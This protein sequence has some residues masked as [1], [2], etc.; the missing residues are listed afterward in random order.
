[1]VYKGW[2]YDIVLLSLRV[3]DRDSLFC[4]YATIGHDLRYTCSSLY[5]LWF[6]GIFIASKQ[7]GGGGVQATAS[8]ASELY[9]VDERR[10][11]LCYYYVHRYMQLEEYTKEK[12]ILATFSL[13]LL[14]IRKNCIMG[15]K[16]RTAILRNGKVTALYIENMTNN[17]LLNESQ[18]RRHCC[19]LA[20]QGSRAK[21][22]W[23]WLFWELIVQSMKD[24]FLQWLQRQCYYCS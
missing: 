15:S 18:R 20:E 13:S 2:Q 17:H 22:W 5:V 7:L 14:L 24:Y 1:M 12:K 4:D 21:Q 19:K 16:E 11:L 9:I 10:H 3:V 8:A 23:W 6:C